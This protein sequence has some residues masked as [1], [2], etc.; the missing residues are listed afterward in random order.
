MA[1]NQNITVNLSNLNIHV[2]KNGHAHNGGT[3]ITNF[4]K[5]ERPRYEKAIEIYGDKSLFISDRSYDCYNSYPEHNS[6]HTV[7]HPYKDLSLF[8]RIFNGL[9]GLVPDVKEA[10]PDAYAELKAAHA[11]GK[12]IQMDING[13]WTDW[14]IPDWTATVEFYRIKPDDY[15][16][17]R[18]AEKAGKTIQ[19]FIR[20]GV[21]KDIVNPNYYYPVC[22]YRI[23]PEPTYRPWTANEIPVGAQWRCNAATRADF[24]I[25]TNSR[26]LITGVTQSGNICRTGGTTRNEDTPE[27]FLK[28]NEHSI[29]FGKTWHP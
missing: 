10:A 26:H 5:K 7:G 9:E 29:D 2:V 14:P 18:D 13:E 27:Y 4:D 20:K 23:K 19:I 11:S 8:W 21:W 24:N 1:T 25:N 3:G 12:M 22:E 15:Q 16:V 6:L 17:F 28:Y